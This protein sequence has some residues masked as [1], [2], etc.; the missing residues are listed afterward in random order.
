[1]RTLIVLICAVLLTACASMSART[2]KAPLVP[3]EYQI[4]YAKI[5]AVERQARMNWGRV[6]WVS[7]PTKRVESP[8]PGDY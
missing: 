5:A 7:L 1:M 6:V 4:D 3:N 2:T 8:Q